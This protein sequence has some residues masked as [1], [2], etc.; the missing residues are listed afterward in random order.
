[1]A[2]QKRLIP[3]SLGMSLDTKTDKLQMEAQLLVAQNV[4]ME[5]RGK[6]QKSYGFANV[7]S[8]DTDDEAITDMLQLNTFDSE[9]VLITDSR[10][11]SY[12]SAANRWSDKQACPIVGTQSL[13]V[14]ANSYEQSACDMAIAGGKAVYCWEDSRGGVWAQANDLASGAVIIPETQLDSDGSRPRAMAC[15]GK[16]FVYFYQSVDEELQVARVDSGAFSTVAVALTNINTTDVIYDVLEFGS[17]MIIAYCNTAGEIEV[18]YFLQSLVPGATANGSPD[19]I[20]IAEDPDVAIN[21]AIGILPSPVSEEVFH[22]TFVNS[23]DGISTTAYDASFDLYKAIVLVDAETAVRNVGA[24]AYG[25]SLDIYWEV[26]DGASGYNNL[27]ELNVLNVTANTVSTTSV[28]QRAAGMLTKPFMTAD[29]QTTFIASYLSSTGLQDTYFAVNRSS[30]IET[31]ILSQLGAGHTTNT[32]GLGGVWTYDARFNF[33]TRRRTRTIIVNSTGYTLTGLN[34]T[35]LDYGTVDLGSAQQLGGNLHIGGGFIKQYDGVSVVEHNFH[36]YPE[37]PSAVTAASGT[38]LAN[39]TYNYIVIWEWIDNQGQISRST[40]SIPLAHTVSGGPK[41]VTLTIPTLRYTAKQGIR[42]DVIVSI[43]RTEAGPGL[44]YYKVTDDTAPTYNDVDVDSITFTDDIG[45]AALVAQQPL[46]TTGG[47]LDDAPAPAS[48][49]VKQAKNRL[50]TTTE[51]PSVIAFSKAW[52]QSDA[53]AFAAEFTL[54]I[55][56]KGGA[57]TAFAEMDEKLIVFK[58]DV[59]YVV[60]GDGPNDAGQAGEF[61]V[62]AIATDVGTIEP[63]SVVEYKDGV[64]F[65]SAKGIYRLNRALESEYIGAQVEDYNPLMITS[66]V[67]VA[68]QNVLRFTTS[69]GTTLS[70]NYFFGQWFTQTRLEALSATV[71]LGQYTLLTTNDVVKIETVGSYANS[72]AVI[73]SKIQTGWIAMAGI[74]GLQRLYSIMLLG[75]YQGLCRLTVSIKYNYIDTIAETFNADLS[76]FAT[77]Y[78]TDTYGDEDPYGGMSIPQFQFRFQPGLQKCEAFSIVI[79]DG[80]PTSDPSA[81]FTLSSM[82]LEVGGKVGQFKLPNVRSIPS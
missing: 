7:S 4:A 71:W 67:V 55:P 48:N 52:N 29:N 21:L 24:V 68:E 65:K 8:L 12:G 14:V 76:E 6:L 61:T 17:K 18:T 49:V 47:I 50:W 82:N 33:A 80:F 20:T 39:G 69:I 81:G 10:L 38:G 26:D 34:R 28:V 11:Y 22:I 16:L 78:G 35:I 57:V 56:R 54:A 19:P 59:M 63:D 41:D 74:Q 58:K 77:T 1:M 72:G 42:T 64:V 31:K 13:P 9:L 51:S 15:G 40:T 46:Y 44:T 43:F 25:T 70:Y 5:K 45:D 62:E 53:V 30:E 23:V 37:T 66:A 3:V 75:E 60:T 27:V 36:L 79:E 73:R 2:L 32:S